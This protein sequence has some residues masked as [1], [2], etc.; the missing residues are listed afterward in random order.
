MN[1]SYW[2]IRI[3]II[4]LQLSNMHIWSCIERIKAYFSIQTIIDLHYEY[5]CHLAL[6]IN[7]TQH[8]SVACF[9][10]IYIYC[11]SNSVADTPCTINVEAMNIDVYDLFFWSSSS[12][13]FYR[14]RNRSTNE[15][16]D[17]RLISKYT[18]RFNPQG[19][20]V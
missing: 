11:S 16:I 17:R 2:H 5:A 9:L 19:K 7:R 13:I 6:G 20:G 1:E 10:Y 4:C 12:E 15:K 14:S 3:Y 18:F 8:L